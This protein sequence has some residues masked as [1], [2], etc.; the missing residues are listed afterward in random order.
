MDV[1]EKFKLVTELNWYKNF[2]SRRSYTTCSGAMI[3]ASPWKGWNLLQRDLFLKLVITPLLVSSSTCLRG[4]ALDISEVNIWGW[5]MAVAQ[6]MKEAWGYAL[7]WTA[8]RYPWGWHWNEPHNWSAHE[9]EFYV[10]HMWSFSMHCELWLT[11]QQVLHRPRVG[12]VA[13]AFHGEF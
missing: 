8:G 4:S 6:A 11:W 5:N 12:G 3:R 13:K 1:K 7:V 10:L 9:A 2:E